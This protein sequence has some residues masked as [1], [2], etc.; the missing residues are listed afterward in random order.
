MGQICMTDAGSMHIGGL[1]I[2]QDWLDRMKLVRERTIP[3]ILPSGKNI[4]GDTMLKISTGNTNLDT[5][6]IQSRLKLANVWCNKGGD[7]CYH[8]CGMVH[9]KEHLLLI[10][11]SSTFGGSWFSLSQHSI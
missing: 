6:Q 3:I 2:T 1:P 4:L 7:M 8:F 5:S 10:E 9:I 11:N